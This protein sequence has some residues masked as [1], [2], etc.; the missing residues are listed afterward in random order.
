ML[1]DIRYRHFVDLVTVRIDDRDKPAAPIPSR[2]DGPVFEVTCQRQRI[3]ASGSIAWQI[4]TF[5]I[6]QNLFAVTEVEVITRHA[7]MIRSEKY[8]SSSGGEIGLRVVGS[9]WVLLVSAPCLLFP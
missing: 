4:N 7:E 5:V 6:V 9:L 1:S 2:H 8:H 3:F